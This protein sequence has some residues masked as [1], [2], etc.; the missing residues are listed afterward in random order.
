MT[1]QNMTTTTKLRAAARQAVIDNVRERATLEHRKNY[2]K[3]HVYRDGDVDWTEHINRS[4][5]IIDR[6][7]KHFAPIPSVACVGTGSCACNCDFCDM[8][9]SEVDEAFALENG[10]EYDKSSKFQT[11]ED[12][13]TDAVAESDLW[14]LEAD[15]LREFNE[16]PV[17]YFNDED[18]LP[19]RVLARWNK[20]DWDDERM[21]AAQ[22]RYY[23]AQTGEE[24]ELTEEQASR[25]TWGQTAD[26]ITGGSQAGDLRE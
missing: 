25:Y 18:E 24:I 26:N 14:E 9:Y 21:I 15:M 10:R 20:E 7:A 3:L 16:I 17:G 19:Q 23:D 12:A 1:K 22:Y 11:Q 13:I 4:D 2:H 8:I 6:D 5:D